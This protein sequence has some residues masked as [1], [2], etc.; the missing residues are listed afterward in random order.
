VIRHAAAVSGSPVVRQGRQVRSPHVAP[1]AAVLASAAIFVMDVTAATLGTITGRHWQRWRLA[2]KESLAG[3][4][5]CGPA[6]GGS[7]LDADGMEGIR[8]AV[9]Q[10]R[11][12][13]EFQFSLHP[14][15]IQP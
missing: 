7:S 4:L 2:R 9:N 14:L 1:L 11:S 13:G 8:D 12:P 10:D 15:S 5:V 3:I 6:T